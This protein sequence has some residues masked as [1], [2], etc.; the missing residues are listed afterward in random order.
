MKKACG[1][2]ITFKAS[3]G[4]FRRM[5]IRNQLVNRRVTSIGQKFPD[6]AV[7]LAEEFLKD[8]KNI[9]DFS[10]IANMDETPCYFDIPRTSTIDKRGVS[11]VKV[12][13]TGHERLR[14]T[15]ALTAGVERTTDGF[16]AFRLPPLKIQELKEKSTREIP[17]GLQVLG[18]QEGGT[19][20]RAMMIES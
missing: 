14:F 13:T 4:W 1:V 19:I 9:G 20:T 5:C 3:T 8:M 18:S 12:K 2:N 6:N 17:P 10:N 15:V 11:T 7:E 16:S